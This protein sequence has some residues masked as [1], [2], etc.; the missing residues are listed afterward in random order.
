MNYSAHYDR[1][2]ERARTRTLTGYVERHHVVP[3]CLDKASTD[4]VRLTP[5]EHFV[6]HQ[7]LMKTHPKHAGL[8]FAAIAMASTA[9]CLSR[10][11]KLFGWLR[12]QHGQAMSVRIRST[13][14]RAN[15]RGMTG[16]THTPETRL[17][18]SAAHK[19]VPKSLSHR[20]AIS[21]SLTG[22]SRSIEHRAALSV[23]H[24][25]R[26]RQPHTAETRARMVAAWRLR[27]SSII[28]S[29]RKAG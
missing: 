13:E 14:E 4:T 15:H 9:K 6:A 12:R 11:N 17:R 20:A 19:G 25:G 2:I 5:E 23:A 21:L 3:L 29:E 18:M 26:K 1:L 8:A 27:R 10:K 28:S 16:R 24:L 7:L 22:L